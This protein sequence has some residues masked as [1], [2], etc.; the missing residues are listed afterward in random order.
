[1]NG[2]QAGV[3]LANTILFVIIP[4]IIQIVLLYLIY[5]EVKK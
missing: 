5:K 3:N 1:M 4:E 2:A